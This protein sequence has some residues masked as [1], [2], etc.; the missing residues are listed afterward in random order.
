MHWEKWHRTVEAKK[1]EGYSLGVW[2]LMLGGD[3]SGGMV[4]FEVVEVMGAEMEVGRKD[5]M[6]ESFTLKVTIA[7]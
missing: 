4:M 5:S 1:M 6:D 3:G 7:E 2:C